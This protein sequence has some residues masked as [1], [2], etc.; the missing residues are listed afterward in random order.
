MS[1]EICQS[2]TAGS[3]RASLHRLTVNILARTVSGISS[4]SVLWLLDDWLGRWML[5]VRRQPW[6]EGS[7]LF[8]VVCAKDSRNVA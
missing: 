4:K 7:A 2:S 5:R 1:K 6:R 3:T 8:D